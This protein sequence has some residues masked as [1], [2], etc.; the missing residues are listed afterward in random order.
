MN[1]DALFGLSVLRYTRPDI[2]AAA[3]A[4]A[5]ERRAERRCHIVV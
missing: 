2:L 3:A 1:I 5:I 4:E